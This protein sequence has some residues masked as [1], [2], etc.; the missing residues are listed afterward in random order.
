MHYARSKKEIRKQK[1]KRRKKIKIEKG[2]RGNV[3]AQKEKQP[4]AHLAQSRTGILFPLSLSLPGGTRMSA[5]SPP[6]FPL[7]SLEMELA[8][9][10]P[11]LNSRE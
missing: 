10:K 1:K 6:P 11:P 9:V 8:G 5:S 4:A 7:F 2:P 3:S